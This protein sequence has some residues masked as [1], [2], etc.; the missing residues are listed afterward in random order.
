MTAGSDYV[1]RTVSPVD[2]SV[3]AERPLATPAVV[4]AALDRAVAAQRAWRATPMDERVDVVERLV[5]WMV[6]R[7]DDIG[8]ELAWQMGRPVAQAPAEITRG[9]AER[10][11]WLAGAAADALA[12]DEIPAPGP[13]LRRFIRREP[14]GVVLVVAPWNYPYLCSVNAVVAALLAGNAVVLKM[15]AQTPLVAERW[16]EGLAAAGLPE[17]VFGY[18]HADHD[19]VAALCGDPRVGY[20]AFTGSVPGGRAV[21]RATAAGARFVGTGFELGGKD[22]AYV[23]ADAPLDS[24][25]AGLVDGVCFNAGQS[26]CAVERIYVDRRV[27]DD[28]VAGFVAGARSYVLDD[29]LAPTTTLGPLVRAGAAAFVRGQVDAAVAAGATPLVDPGAFPRSQEGTPYLAPQVL[30]GVDHA[31]RIMTEE[32]FG[33]VVG[34]MPVAGDDEAVALMNDSRYGLTASIWTADADAAVAVGDR[35]ETGTWYM[36][37]CDYLDPALA[38]T[39][40]KDSGRGVT[41]STLG[42]RAMTR[43]KSFHLRAAP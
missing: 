41:L 10:A 8:R 15:A 6:A 20:V 17:G 18:L 30:V 19:A 24:T 3:V 36:N 14:V 11:R 39:G 7:A 35:V 28:V 21:A 12:D 1:Q 33:P 25:I 34:I 5:G 27:F 22:P 23:R 2:G 42:L 26:C 16:A 32:T 31:M 43:P 37:R 40:V 4:D 9:F 38:W 13:G 29:P